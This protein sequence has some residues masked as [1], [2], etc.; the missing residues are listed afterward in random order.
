[1]RSSFH[2]LVDSMSNLSEAQAGDLIGDPKKLEARL[3]KEAKVDAKVT[4]TKTELRIA[5]VGDVTSFQLD[6]VFHI[7]V[8]QPDP[9]RGERDMGLEWQT[10]G[11]SHKNIRY[12]ASGST[13]ILACTL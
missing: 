1:M 5:F 6:G 7:L 9:W 11:F 8:P 4:L 3:K 2:D 10:L 13:V 12:T